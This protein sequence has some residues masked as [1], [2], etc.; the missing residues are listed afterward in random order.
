MNDFKRHFM[1]NYNPDFKVRIMASGK[2]D[3][4]DF[5]CISGCFTTSKHY[6]FVLKKG[7]I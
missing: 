3:P 5:C 7:V 2:H 4:D 6:Q 1:S